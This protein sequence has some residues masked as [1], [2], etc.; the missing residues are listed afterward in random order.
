MDQKNGFV[1][2]FDRPDEFVKITLRLDNNQDLVLR[3]GEAARA[4]MV[5]ERPWSRTKACLAELYETA[6]KNFLAADA[7]RRQVE[8]RPSAAN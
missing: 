4:T 5:R 6:I 8:P 7:S 1:V 2:P 3:I